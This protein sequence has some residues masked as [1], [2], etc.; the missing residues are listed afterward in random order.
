MK[1]YETYDRYLIRKPLFSYRV[2]FHKNETKNI[3]EVVDELINDD[4]FVTSIYWSSPNLYEAIINYREKSLKEDKVSKLIHTLKKYAIRAS[5][6]CTP[7]GTMA[8]VALKDTKNIEQLN[9]ISRKARIDMDF[10]IELILHIEKNENIRK[11]LRYKPNNTIYE[12]PRQYR[13]YELVR[14]I[15]EEKYQLSS[16]EINE[17]IKKISQIPNFI[18][19]DEIKAL[20]SDDFEDS[21]IYEFIDELININFLISEIQPTLTS[22]NMEYIKTRLNEI[23]N[24]GV[25]D[26]EIYIKIFEKIENCISL[27]EKTP[28]SYLPTSEIS[29]IKKLA[30][31][32]GID[33][34]HFFHV[35]LKHSS[36]SNFELDEKILRNINDSISILHK[37]CN[38]NSVQNDIDI[39]KKIFNTKYESREV[40]LAE[41]LDSEFGIEFPAQ[42]Q[43]GNFEGSSLIEGF[44]K[45]K[46]STSKKHN[47]ASNLDFLLDFLEDKKETI[48]LENFNLKKDENPIKVQNFC[49]VGFPFED[50]FFLQNIGT[51]RANSI[52][53]RFGLVDKKIKTL[54][55]EIDKEEQESSEEIIYAEIIYA[56][57]NRTANITRRPKLSEHEIPIFTNSSNHEDKQIL[58]KDIMISIKGNDIILRS[59]KLN[60][61]IIPK[62][63]NAHNFYKSDCIAYKFLS[64]IQSQNQDNLNFNIN[65]SAL[66]KRFFP[67]IIYKNIILHR[68]CWVM[69]ESDIRVVKKAKKPLLELKKFL[70]KW[71]APKYV[72]LVQ[73]DNELF[74][75]TTNDSYLL[76][77]L[78]EFKNNTILQLSEWLQPN[79]N[80]NQQVVIPLKNKVVKTENSLFHDKIKLVQRSFAPGSE[81]L[82]FKIY[83]NSNVSDQLLSGLKSILDD[84]LSENYINS[85][86]FIRYTDPHYHIRLR[87][88]L[89]DKKLYSEVLQKIY[90]NI[91][92][93]FQEEVIWNIQ[94]DS[95]HRELDRYSP[96][97]MEDS[98]KAFYYDSLLILNLLNDENFIDNEN[99][100]LFSAVKN[101]NSWLSF[102]NLSLQEKLDFCKSMENSFLEEF[103]TEL[104][105]Q[106]NSKYRVLKEDLYSFLIGNEFENEFRKRE[107]QLNKIMLYEEALSSY[108]HMSINRW[109][110]SEQRA[111]ELMAYSFSVKYYSRILSQSK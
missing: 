31:S 21:E 47:T 25:K 85:V 64:A 56:P 91:N 44:A 1:K 10:L 16:L 110:P 35:D 82:Y 4:S 52:L 62:L 100:R 43:I 92:P 67:R 45:K 63:S 12:I 94:L 39:F 49:V 36:E 32:L 55:T 108:I 38:T 15:D 7:Y 17:H 34:V 48:N 33:K 107:R 104:K 27:I 40:S 77:L 109:F 103:S 74:L 9:Q 78:D 28:V 53:G 23:F 111:L 102:F 70:Q 42:K 3:E 59:K 68:A 71:E 76:L 66:K 75:D 18:K 65:Y 93:Y 2:L 80:Y 29:E 72:L 8:G 58:L 90:E 89:L 14:N 83:C 30:I 20:F 79:I 95:Y 11:N 6:R 24:E 69:H 19:C 98:E 101:I 51:T 46:E 26:V 22:N 87:L 57:E 37:F 41:V 97:F 60:K 99:I 106:I 84:L 81:W 61:R 105:K 13:Y 54:C 73:G 88:H 96:E 5:T 50:Y 86:F